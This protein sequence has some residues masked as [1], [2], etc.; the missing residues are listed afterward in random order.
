MARPHIRLDAGRWNV[1]R[2]ADDEFITIGHHSL[3]LSQNYDLLRELSQREPAASKRLSLGHT[4]GVL[5]RK[6]GHG[7]M[8]FDHFRGSFSFPLLLTFQRRVRV[9]YLLRCHDYRG[10]VY[11]PLY[12]VVKD[13]PSV[14]ERSRC[15][16]TLDSEFSR[17]EADDFVSAFYGYLQACARLLESMPITPFYRA[18]QSD[19]ILYGHDGSAFFQHRYASWGRFERA[20]LEFETRLGARNP[21]SMADRV[22]QMIDRVTSV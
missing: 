3:Q 7:S 13:E 14:E 1:W 16:A 2:L 9:S 20:R 15:H 11:F 21:R 22:E 8:L 6:F 12:R 19:I 10:I 17:A 4:L 5:E 18:I